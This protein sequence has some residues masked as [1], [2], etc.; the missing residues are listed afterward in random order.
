M[1]A[2]IHG[3]RLAD[4]RITGYDYTGG[5]VGYNGGTVTDCHV[6][7]NVCIHAVKSKA[8]YHGGIV[9]YNEGEGTVENC[10]SAATLTIP[11]GKTHCRYYGAIA[12]YNY[13][14]L[15]DNLAIGATVP[16]AYTNT[17]GAIVGRSDDVGTLQR[18]YYT[19]CKVAG[20]KN[21]TGKGCYDADVDANDGAVPALR[22]QADVTN[23]LALMAKLPKGTYP[24]SF[25]RTFTAGKASTLCLPFAMSSIKG[26]KVYQL[27]DVTYNKGNGE[28]V[29][30]MIDQSPEEGNLLSATEAGKPYLFMPETS[31]P[32]TFAGQFTVT[33]ET[34]TDGF[35]PTDA[36]GTDGWTMK[37]TYE[38]LKY[39]TEPLTGAI[40]GFASKDKE[41]DGVQVQAGEFVRAK[42]GATVPALRA[43]LTYS[44]DNTALQA[45]AMTRAAGD[46][47]PQTITV[48]LISKEGT[49]TATGTVATDTGEL[50]IDPDAWYTLGGHLLPAKPTA[51]GIYINN[52]HIVVIK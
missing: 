16:A 36:N 22:D 10:T 48:R 46:T 51:S 34:A 28:W 42:A 1:D 47:L 25:K 19:A 26:G 2:N 35:A 30:T 9:G 24:A 12:G 33:E 31:D 8:D 41:V 3:I 23:A 20:I 5:I 17:H 29:A 21:A 18:N 32:V 38:E 50:D 27:R 14:I 44:G 45:R 37:G 40:F 52:G 39:G 49:V 15:R 6:A 11:S 4:A 13:G 43:Y 7:S